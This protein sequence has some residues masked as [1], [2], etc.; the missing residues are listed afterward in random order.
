MR[1]PD[2]RITILD[3]YAFLDPPPDTAINITFKGVP[4]G[5]RNNRNARRA[6]EAKWRKGK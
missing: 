1:G 4:V 2:D 5:T 3:P 6:A